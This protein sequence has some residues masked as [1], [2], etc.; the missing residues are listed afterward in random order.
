MTVIGARALNRALLARQLLLQRHAMPAVAALEHLV[1]LQAQEPQEPY[2][3]LWSR[4]VGFAPAELVELL[5]SRQ[6]VRTLLMRRTLHL[7][8]ARDC[9]ALRG[10]HQPMAR[11][12][13]EATGMSLNARAWM[14]CWKRSRHPFGSGSRT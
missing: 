9:L 8:T 2:V 3:G 14:R 11:S 5:E 13:S 10:L 4:L 1:G 12:S 6:A 7:V